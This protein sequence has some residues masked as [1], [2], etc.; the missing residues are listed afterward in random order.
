[1]PFPT[2]PTPCYPLPLKPDSCSDFIC[3]LTFRESSKFQICWQFWAPKIF[4]NLDWV[5]LFVFTILCLCHLANWDSYIKTQSTSSIHTSL[6]I[7]LLWTYI[8]SCIHPYCY[9]Q[10]SVSFPTKLN[11]STNKRYALQRSINDTSVP[12]RFFS[13]YGLERWLTL[14]VL[15]RWWTFGYY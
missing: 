13:L 6:T 15:F 10:M 8:A 3:P 9:L 1:M 14:H 2:T 11:K 5:F 4:S 7:F 12:T